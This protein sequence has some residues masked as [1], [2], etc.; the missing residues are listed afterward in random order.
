MN[1]TNPGTSRAVYAKG[2]EKFIHRTISPVPPGSAFIR[3]AALEGRKGKNSEEDRADPDFPSL[4][5][6]EEQEMC[7]WEGF[8]P[9]CQPFPRALVWK[10][11]THE[12]STPSGWFHV[13]LEPVKL[14][15]LLGWGIKPALQT[16]SQCCWED[17]LEMRTPLV[18]FLAA[19]LCV[20]QGE[21]LVLLLVKTRIRGK[22]V[23]VF[24]VAKF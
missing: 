6:P 2:P 23:T 13:H 10:T 1:I 11:P 20:E 9:R 21:P 12:H 17:L 5:R 19:V 3:A 24:H 22:V 4:T 8:S 15:L 7:G 18:T 16:A 14:L